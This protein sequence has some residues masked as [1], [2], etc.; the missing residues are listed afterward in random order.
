[1]KKVLLLVSLSALAAY[2]VV[3]SSAQTPAATSSPAV[4]APSPS[5][6]STSVPAVAGQESNSV[7]DDNLLLNPSFEEAAPVLTDEKSLPGWTLKFRKTPNE[8]PLTPNE[9]ALIE[10]PAQAHSGHSFLRLQPTNRSLSFSSP[11]QQGYEPGIYEMSAWLRGHPGTLGGFGV[12]ALK[13]ESNFRGLTDQWQKFETTVYFKGSA[14]ISPPFIT[15]FVFNAQKAKE[16]DPG[17]V[18][19]G[20]SQRSMVPKT[21]RIRWSMSMMRVSCA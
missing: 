5:P 16:A 19:C 18:G 15:E 3:S 21:F 13:G 10:D 2:F 8:P 4:A 9:A 7:S 11:E 14:K 1:M 17:N 20:G 12:V 6:T